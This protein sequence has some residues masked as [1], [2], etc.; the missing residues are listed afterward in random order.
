MTRYEAF[1]EKSWRTTGLTQLLV[2]RIRDNG[3]ADIGFFLVDLWCLGIKDAFFHDDVSEAEFKELVTERLPEAYR[4]RF[5][6]ACA[7]KMIDGALAYAERLGFAPHRDYRKARRAL[8]G[9]DATACPETF[10]FGRDGQPFYV[11]GPHDTPER[12]QRILAMLEARCGADG[13]GCELVGDADAELDEARDALRWFFAELEAENSPDFYEFAGMVAALQVCPTLVPPTQL[14][15]RLFGPAGHTWRDADEAKD[16]A[17]DLGVYWNYIA[18]LIAA[19]AAAAPD[20]TEAD[21]L[22][23]YE[24][25]FDDIDDATKAE[26]LASAFINW[27]AGFMRATREWPDAWGDALTRADLAPYWRVVRAWADPDIPEHLAIL[28]GDEKSDESSRKASRLP[29]AILTLLRALRRSG[30]P[31]AP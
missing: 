4:E 15:A 11:E 14:L 31:A 3:R 23:I 5:H 9:L 8:S 21:P 1:I 26:Y 2:A 28:Q 17:D 24:D 12:T 16:F 22:D 29:F 30:P 25:D 7:K 20:D 6:P 19:C 27:A 18:D 13:F 10:T